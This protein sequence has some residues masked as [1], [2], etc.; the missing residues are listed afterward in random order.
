MISILQ[1]EA[2]EQLQAD[3]ILERDRLEHLVCQGQVLLSTVQSSL[4]HVCEA[5]IADSIVTQSPTDAGKYIP[6]AVFE[7]K[8]G[9]IERIE[10]LSGRPIDFELL[11]LFQDPLIHFVAKISMRF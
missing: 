7:A 3:N 2:I 4:L 5:Q 10:L 11:I 8:T 6:H 1:V 9:E